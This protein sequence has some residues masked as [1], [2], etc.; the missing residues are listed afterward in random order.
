MAAF[1]IVLMVLSALV[2]AVWTSRHWMIR[3]QRDADL[4]TPDSPGP[5]ADPPL[6]SV[7]VAAKDE[8]DNIETCLRSLL[9]QDYPRFEVIAVND[10]SEDDTGAI[11][12]RIAAG[13]DRLR[14]IHVDDL[15]D[16]WCGKNNAMARGIAEARSDWLCM[17]DADCRYDSPRTLS[18]AVQYARDTDADLLSVLPELEMR[19]FW[20]RVIQPVCSGVMM[21]WF[22]PE[23]VNN[24][25]RA[26]AY[27]NGAFM[28][29]RRETYDAVGG[30]AAV[31]DRVNEDMHM[32]DRVKR[33]G[34]QLRVVS[35][36]G[37][38]SVRMYESLGAILRG[39]SRIFFGT[40][41]TLKR[42]TLSLVV[43]LMMGLLPYAAAIAGFAGVAAG[44][45]PA[46]LWWACGCVGAAA[47]AVQLSVIVRYYRLISARP[48]LA[49]TYPLACGIV[50]VILLRS[51]AKL[52]PGATVT[53]RGTSY[54]APS[55]GA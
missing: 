32:A 50:S 17:T 10:R 33:S 46:G 45:R 1:P 7:L 39:W 14:C 28:L 3:R 34:R 53:W 47:A 55:D 42:L 11:M 6:V 40:F 5:P 13:D 12:D 16:G 9:S 26:N 43:L 31:R 22:H 4:L 51:L 36:K 29:M 35:N 2:A 30:H 44:A 8:A 15:P 54:S 41:G 23:K 18:A 37:L 49:W 24:P 38:Y 52:R 19:T 20:E 25:D 48:S 27:A 21:I